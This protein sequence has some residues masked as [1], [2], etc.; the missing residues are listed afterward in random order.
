ML[1]GKPPPVKHG[2]CEMCGG[3]NRDL[4]IL[5]LQDFIG[6]TCDECRDQIGECLARRYIPSG[7]ATEPA[8]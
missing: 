6:W 1:V 7:E 4:R 3:H 8:E 5:V 2:T